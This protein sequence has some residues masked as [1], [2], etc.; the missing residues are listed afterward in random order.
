[1]QDPTAWTKSSLTCRTTPCSSHL[2][3]R[4]TG[5]REAELGL[6]WSTQR[7][8]RGRSSPEHWLRHRYGL[9]ATGWAGRNM[10]SS[11]GGASWVSSCRNHVPPLL[12]TWATHPQVGKSEKPID[13]VWGM[14]FSP[15]VTEFPSRVL[16]LHYSPGFREMVFGISLLETK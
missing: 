11:W 8:I 14:N 7:Q 10:Q 5:G 6:P 12:Y 1:M 2:G 13:L 16:S 15:F 9:R 3:S 4:V